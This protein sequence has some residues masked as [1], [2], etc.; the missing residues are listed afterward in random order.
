MAFLEGD[1]YWIGTDK[2]QK[3][4]DY[5]DAHPDCVGLLPRHVVFQDDGIR[6]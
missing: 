5:L 1:D 2:L 4:V 6:R 3:Q